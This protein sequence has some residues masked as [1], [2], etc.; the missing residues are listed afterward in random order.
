LEYEGD[1]GLENKNKNRWEL[2]TS[3][4]KGTMNALEKGRQSVGPSERFL[5]NQAVCL[6]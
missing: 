6:K 2:I 4:L 5:N 3:S 1:R